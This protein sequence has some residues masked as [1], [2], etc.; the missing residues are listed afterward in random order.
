VG[1]FYPAHFN[2]QVLGVNVHRY[3]FGVEHLFKFGRNLFG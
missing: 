3:V 2:A 1:V